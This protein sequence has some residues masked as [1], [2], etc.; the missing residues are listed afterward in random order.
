[1][2]RKPTPTTFVFG[3]AAK[4]ARRRPVRSDTTT[5]GAFSIP[6]GVPFRKR[7]N[8]ARLCAST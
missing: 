4:L 7:S 2:P 8:Q 6:F 3:Q 1:M 5:A